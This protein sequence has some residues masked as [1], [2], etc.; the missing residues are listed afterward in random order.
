MNLTT[1]PNVF[2]LQGRQ[3]HQRPIAYERLHRGTV[4]G[5]RP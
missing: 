3:E 4:A 5:R 2:A 1:I